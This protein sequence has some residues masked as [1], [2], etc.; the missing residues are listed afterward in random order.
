MLDW[1]SSGIAFLNISFYRLQFNLKS[2]LLIIL[3]P[4]VLYI[5]TSMCIICIIYRIYGRILLLKIN[6]VNLCL[7]ALCILDFSYFNDNSE[8]DHTWIGMLDF[9]SFVL[10][11]P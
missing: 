1:F 4:L 9:Y 3:G 6:I 8:G 2:R 7:S 5:Y 11:D 10:V